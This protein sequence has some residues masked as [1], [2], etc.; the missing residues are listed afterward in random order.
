[1]GEQRLAS[2]AQE[3]PTQLEEI[4]FQIHNEDDIPKSPRSSLPIVMSNND[5]CDL[6]LEM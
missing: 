1:M 3:Q 5:N 4:N 2:M 6:K